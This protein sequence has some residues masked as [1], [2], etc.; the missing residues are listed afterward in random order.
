M[1]IFMTGYLTIPGLEAVSPRTETRKISY[2]QE[3]F[4]RMIDRISDIETT[5][6]ER[7]PMGKQDLRRLK[8]I[9]S[10]RLRQ[11]YRE[12]PEE[13]RERVIRYKSQSSTRN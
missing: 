10:G 8:D 12:N 1:G 4:D 2:T 11:Y 13:S 7:S 3:Q 9:I 5:L 6:H